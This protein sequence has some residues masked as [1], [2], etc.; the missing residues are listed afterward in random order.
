MRVDYKEDSTKGKSLMVRP[1]NYKGDAMVQVWVDS[2]VLATLS[3]WLDDNG[4]GTRFMSEVVRDSLKVLCNYLVETKQATIVDHTTD[5]R[6]LLERKYRV[7][8]NPSGRGMKNVLHNKLISEKRVEMSEFVDRREQ[9]SDVDKVIDN[10]RGSGYSGDKLD[11]AVRIYKEL[12]MKEENDRLDEALAKFTSTAKIVGETEDGEP[13][14]QFESN[15]NSDINEMPEG[16][17][18][19][20]RTKPKERSLPTIE[21]IRKDERPRSLTPEE[22]EDL[23]IERARKDKEQLDAFA[24]M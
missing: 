1:R 22:I 15:S 11:E 19:I 17:G 8:L 9:G 10:S 13:L 20:S 14:Y 23:R 6:E 4:Q 5:A 7:E 2:R 12:E 21:G 18:G 3:V 24:K 16:W